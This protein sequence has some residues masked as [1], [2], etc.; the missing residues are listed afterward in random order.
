MKLK[1]KF[2]I[3]IQLAIVAV[4]VL[5]VFRTTDIEAYCPLGGLLSIAS[6]T[7]SGASSCQMGETQL[8]M[9]L[10]LVLGIFVLGKVFCSH[11]CPIGTVTEWLGRW[12]RKFKMQ[13]KS[14]PNWLDSSLRGL[15]YALLLPVLY[16][17]ATSNELFCK[18]FEP[19]YG[20]ATGFG[21]DTVLLW[22]VS[23]V[24]VTIIGSFFIRQ[25]WC[26]YLC[27]LGALSNLFA[28]S[29]LSLGSLAVY[30]GIRY[31]GVD[32]SI[33]WLFLTWAVGGFILELTR[34]GG[35]MTPVLRITRN[36][37][38]CTDC[39]LCD[40]VC[41]YDIK[42]S[43][44]EKVKHVDCTMC[45]DCVAACPVKDTLTI[46]GKNW[47][48]LPAVATAVLIVLGFGFASQ[49]ELKTLD[50]RWGNPAAATELAQFETTVRTVKCFGSASS[51]MRKVRGHKG[52]Y[53]MD[54]YAKSHKVVFYYEPDQIN[55]M[56]IKE[57]IFSPYKVRIR[58]FGKE[59]PQT[60]SVAYFGVNNLND[61]LDNNNFIRALRQSDY[62][63]GFETNFGEPVR[64]LVYYNGAEITPADIA[65]LIEVKEITYTTRDK[66]QETVKLNF[67]VEGTPKEV[68]QIDDDVF[69]QHLFS[70]FART[71]KEYDAYDPKSVK[72]Y[73]IGMPNV[74]SPLVRRYLP[75]LMSHVSN[76]DG[77]LG[78]ETF[79]TKHAVGWIYYDPAKTDTAKI[80]AALSAPQMTVNF[81]SG[82]T[83][84]YQN[85]FRFAGPSQIRDVENLQAVKN[86]LDQKIAFTNV[87]KD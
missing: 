16:Y 87:F 81:S 75:Y 39:K 56:G 26:K 33:F 83:K 28:F 67:E 50:E 12:G 19:Y 85:P 86:N 58:N 55:E 60:I 27:P 53:G 37:P 32:L 80:R 51:L 38:S 71:F 35:T 21:A 45:A 84:Q 79:Y 54:A 9:G 61:N 64:V 11:I 62:I 30:I 73:E 6:R 29:L 14:M 46:T 23:A 70:P 22:S 25:F 40:K 57:A 7:V 63:Y 66:K 74:E 34:K 5:A 42:V 41:P 69:F 24:V 18:T 47:K 2:R 77:V 3:F 78:L 59:R 13:L 10:A 8:F 72:V 52:I 43:E 20:A 65:K 82:E 31:A 4:V 17:T 49:Y 68:A 1:N 76:T 36:I 15:K 44:M 48:W